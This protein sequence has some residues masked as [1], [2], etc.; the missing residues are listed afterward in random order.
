MTR[1]ALLLGSAVSMGLLLAAGSARAAN[2][3]AEIMTLQKQIEQTPKMASN[4][5]AIPTPS[6]GP[7]PLPSP[8]STAREPGAT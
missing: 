4:A 7:A 8:S 3:S 6:A 2:C 1:S 5:N